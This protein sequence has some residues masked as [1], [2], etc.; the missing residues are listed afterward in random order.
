MPPR[1]SSRDPDEED[2]D[3]DRPRKA[4]R[5]APRRAARR[6]HPRPPP[7][8]WDED[9]DDE[10]E[11]DEEEDDDGPRPSH[12]RSAEE[13]PPKEPVFFRAR[14]STF[15]EL[16]VAVAVLAILLAAL[17]AYTQ[18]FPPMYVVESDSMQHGSS[19]V[20]GLIN[21]GDLVL[22]QKVPASQL[23]TYET[24]AQTG[25][26]TYGEYGDVILYHPDGIT[27]GA[28]IIHRAIL[29]IQV[30]SDGS[31]SFPTLAGEPCGSA[32]NAVYS[33]STTA[34]GCG[35][36]HVS[37]TL[38]LYH[39]GWR[40]VTV[41]VDLASLGGSSG[42]LT[43]GDNNFDPANDSIGDP[44]QPALSSLVEPG[45]VLGVARGMLPWF[46]AVKLLVSGNAGE[47]PPQSWEWMGLSV[48]GLI[49]VALGIHWLLRAEGIE[50][51]RRKEDDEAARRSAGRGRRTGRWHWPHPLR[52]WG[53]R[54]DGESDD[55]EEGSP[56]PRSRTHETRPP[57]RSWFGGRPKPE[58]GRRHSST[59]RSRDSD[60]DL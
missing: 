48:V 28:P 59:H 60:D 24:G 23:T 38:T 21:T 42:F 47:V 13:T 29:F 50:D 25:Y 41:Q 1:R 26:T 45:W 33:V 35:T 7:R 8:R 46:G 39:V 3:D 55:E 58:V 4:S 27:G 32:P 51:E 10:E 17:F 14:D 20:L 12:R 40:S 9:E 2:D 43:M 15:F 53:D 19:D 18:N 34:N 52:D 49:L 31:S 56:P 5:S 54:Q 22:A 11:E 37:G 30:N 36:D 6:S 44:D 16:L 57:R